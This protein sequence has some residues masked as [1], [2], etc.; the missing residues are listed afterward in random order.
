EVARQTGGMSRAEMASLFSRAGVGPRT[1][2]VVRSQSPDGP[3][4]KLAAL[5]NQG[6]GV[7]DRP[8]RPVSHPQPVDQP[9]RDL[10]P[11]G[12]ETSAQ[13]PAPNDLIASSVRLTIS[14]PTGV[15]YGSGTLIDARAGEALVLT[16]GHIF[17]D[18]QGKGGIA[19][20]MLG[21]G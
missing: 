15:S 9:L 11:R 5:Q 19:I 10:P 2:P 12:F 16:C 20:D 4:G 13:A 3:R 8:L 7:I 6:S 18:S 21:P 17:R 14:D 1:A